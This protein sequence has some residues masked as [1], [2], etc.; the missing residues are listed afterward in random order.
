MEHLYD[1]LREYAKGDDYPLHMPG[2]KRRTFGVLP[3][4]LFSMDI[5]EIPDFD[6]LHAPEGVL[7]ELEERVAKL[8]GASYRLELG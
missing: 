1:K 8:Y 4:D 5:T 7:K 2:H 6:D 3:E